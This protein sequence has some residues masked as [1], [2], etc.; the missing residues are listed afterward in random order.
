MTLGERI[1][2]VK[3]RL[4]EESQRLSEINSDYDD[5][6]ID[7]VAKTLDKLADE[8]WEINGEVAKLEAQAAN[9]N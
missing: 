3:D 4:V 6:R 2:A 7:E 9:E 5:E 8:L 1:T